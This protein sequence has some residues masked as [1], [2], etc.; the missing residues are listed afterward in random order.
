M[1]S[2]KKGMLIGAILVFAG[3][4]SIPFVYKYALFFGFSLFPTILASLGPVVLIG[5]GYLLI[6]VM[7]TPHTPDTD[8]TTIINQ[9]STVPDGAA[10]VSKRIVIVLSDDGILLEC[11]GM[12]PLEAISILEL[13]KY[14]VI[15]KVTR[16][17]SLIDIVKE[18]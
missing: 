5:G 11:K 10:N 7:Q 16:M 14:H 2:K 3:V 17:G 18:K 15:T 1:D 12:S 6:S 4:A 9:P 8:T 13:S